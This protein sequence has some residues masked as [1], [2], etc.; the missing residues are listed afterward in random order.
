MSKKSDPN[1]KIIAENR[2]A[3]FDYFI[4]SDLEAGIMLLGSEVKSL[5]DGKAKI[6]PV[7]PVDWPA[8]RLIVTEGLR[9]GDLLIEDASGLQ[10]GQEV[11]VTGD[12]ASAAQSSVGQTPSTKDIPLPIDK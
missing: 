9:A 12:A 5:R 1:S 2:R 4:E 3:R 7:Q 6:T 8:A 11:A 10:D